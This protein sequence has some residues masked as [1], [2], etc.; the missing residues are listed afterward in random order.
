MDGEWEPRQIDN[1]ACKGISGCGPWKA[2]EISNPLYVG[3]W[4][5]PMVDNPDYKVPPT[6]T[7]THN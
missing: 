4:K 7:T 2:P 1:P 3:V 6:T 5:A